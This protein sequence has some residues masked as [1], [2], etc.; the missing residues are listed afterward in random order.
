MC[1]S[2]PICTNLY[3]ETFQT[4]LGLMLLAM[5]ERGVCFLHFGNSESHLR[6]TLQS[7]FPLASLTPSRAQHKDTARQVEKLVHQLLTNGS[8]E[9]TPALFF[10]GTPFQQDVWRYLRTIPPGEVR[11]YADVAKSI[12]RPRAVRAAASA[13]ARNTIALLVPCHRVIRG[14]G[15]FGGYRW[16][17]DKKASLL[18]AEKRGLHKSPSTTTK[19]GA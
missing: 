14:D 1:A 15:A 4:S 16:G 12:G 11:T 5:S 6:Q 13:C 3:Y 17:I 2:T 7:T 10:Q 9:E 19:A 8:C 18:T